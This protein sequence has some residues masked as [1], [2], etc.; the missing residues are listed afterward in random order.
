MITIQKSKGKRSRQVPVSLEMLTMLR[1]YWLTHK[2]QNLIFP[3][4]APKTFKESSSTTTPMR[5]DATHSVLRNV[6]KTLDLKKHVTPHTFRHCYATHLLDG[7]VNIRLVQL[8]LGHSSIQTTCIYLHVTKHG[9]E[10][11]FDV[12]SSLTRGNTG[13]DNDE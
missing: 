5:I 12:I 11:A 1:K 7:G 6:V 13:G 2:N 9:L 3:S 8:F 10:N 4:R